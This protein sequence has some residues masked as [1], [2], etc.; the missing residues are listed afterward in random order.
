M[1]GLKVGDRVICNGT[2]GNGHFINAYGIIREVDDSILPYFI[3]FGDKDSP[4]TKWWVKE[5]MVVRDTSINIIQD[6]LPI[7]N[8]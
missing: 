4:Q 5:K 2:E 1:K 6:P 8:Y 3:E 7:L